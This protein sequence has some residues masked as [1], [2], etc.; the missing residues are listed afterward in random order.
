MH[1]FKSHLISSIMTNQKIDD[2]IPHGSATDSWLQETAEMLVTKTL[3]PTN[4]T[5]PVF[6]MHR[7]FLH[8]A[9]L[10]VD[11]R[12]AI[13]WENG[14][15]VVRHWKYWLPHFLAEGCTII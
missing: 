8:H 3:M 6:K 14:P 7:S 2:H 15:Q 5:D 12:E 1:A 13:R 4:S 9:F 10:F 11:L